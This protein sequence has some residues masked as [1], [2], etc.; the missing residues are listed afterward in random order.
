MHRSATYPFSAFVGQE[1]MLTGLLLNAVN[2]RIGGIL[3]RGEKGTG[4]STVVRSLASLLPEIEVVEGCPF[5]CDPRAP[6]TL[7][8]HCRERAARGPLPPAVLQTR[9][10]ELPVSATEDRVAGTLDME[11][12]LK[13]GEKRFEP[14]ILAAA[15]RG[16]LYVD[17]VNLL[18]DHLVDLLLDS[19]AMGVNTVEREG[20]SFTH[21][22]RFI[23]VGTMNPEE[24]DL[25][26]QFL[27]RFGLCVPIKGIRDL[28]QRDLLLRR[29]EAFDADPAAFR[30]EWA[31]AE[32]AL[33]A[34]I[35]KA[36][37]ILTGVAA[38]DGILRAITELAVR[39]DVD[40]HRADLTILKTAKTHAA[41]QD[42]DT[43]T[44]EDVAVAAKFALIHRMRRTPFDEV[45]EDMKI[46]DR[47]LEEIRAEGCAKKKIPEPGRR[48]NRGKPPAQG[49]DRERGGSGDLPDS[50]SQGREAPG[51]VEETGA[52]VTVQPA[53]EARRRGAWLAR[54]RGRSLSVVSLWRGRAVR[55]G[56]R[57][58]AGG[59]ALDATLRA[60]APRAVRRPRGPLAIP[61][62]WE[63]LRNKV[64]THKA[65]SLYVFVVDASGSMGNELMRRTKAAVL[66]LLE[67]AYR[68][69]SEAALVAFKARAAELLLPPTRS[70]SLARSKLRELPTGGT[71][72]LA[73]GLALGHQVARRALARPR[74]RGVR[75]LL[76]LVTD[77][78]AN[79]SG[80]PGRARAHAP[81]SLVEEVF[82]LAGRI[83]REAGMRAMVIDTDRKHPASLGLGREI[84]ARMGACYLA[85]ED[86]G[87]L[88]IA[89]AITDPAV[90]AAGRTG[91]RMG[92]RA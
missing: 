77:G 21:P 46:V 67:Q 57:T 31:P 63:D 33:K 24:G 29:Q 87:S 78:R 26:P 32:E 75:P 51:S 69:R 27:D 85:V 47:L 37:A 86:L 16:I 59:L 70:L 48:L 68:D 53:R 73:A 84:A 92:L 88:D 42:R 76:V 49:P 20:V 19:A 25:R 7:C 38:S 23:L 74:G 56:P 52:A 2:P 22:A 40:G 6:D 35:V 91:E 13:T 43:V 62:R 82:A 41:F 18:E 9:V 61:V 11:H 28:E 54:S 50:V 64:R 14:G 12:A 30:G 60:A 8:P 90:L 66:D 71:T 39:L 17:E 58:E 80:R 81:A 15:H 72:P 5:H 3:I 79:V 1:M 44:L 55:A 34:R 4:K 89:R 10:V 45:P 65:G 83:G 36:M